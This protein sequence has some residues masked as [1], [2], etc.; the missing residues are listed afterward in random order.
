MEIFDRRT[1]AVVLL[2]FTLATLGGCNKSNPGISEQSRGTTAPAAGQ[3]IQKIQHIVFVV[4]EN[5][6]FDH[7]FGAFPGADGV[8]KGMAS[9]GEVALEHAPDISPHDVG[10]SFRDA[11]LEFIL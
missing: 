4:K 6:T 1:A 5:R 2:G 7:Y 3:G 11:I 8:T 9:K 10:H